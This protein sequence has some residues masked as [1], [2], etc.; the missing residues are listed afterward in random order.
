MMDQTR[1]GQFQSAELSAPEST[2]GGLQKAAPLHGAARALSFYKGAGAR[3]LTGSALLLLTLLWISAGTAPVTA[4]GTVN[5][6]NLVSTLNEDNTT[7][8]NGDPIVYTIIV[9]NG[10]NHSLTDISILDVL[11]ENVLDK[12]ACNNAPTAIPCNLINEIKEI[13]EPLGGTLTVTTTRQISWTVTNLPANSTLTRSFTA[14][15]IGQANGAAFTNI[16]YASYFELG[17]PATTPSNEVKLN[18]LPRIDQGGTTTLS[19]TPTWFSEDVGGTLSSDWADFDGDGDLDLAL[20]STLGTTVYRNDGGQMEQFWTSPRAAYGVRWADVTGDGKPELVAVGAT[21]NSGDA[22]GNQAQLPGIN[23]IYKFDPTTGATTKRFVDLTNFKS[24]K[25]MVRVEVADFNNDGFI[26]IVAST[27]AINPTCA[28]LLYTN[29]GKGNFPSPGTCISVAATAALK[30][31]DF[32]NDGDKDLVLGEFPNK[33]Q[34]LVNENGKFDPQNRVSIEEGALFLPYDFAW[35]DFD[36]DGFLDLAA[37]YPLLREVRI[38]RNLS[39]VSGTD[40]KGSF[41]RPITLRTNVFL[42]PYSIDWGDFSGDGRIDLAVADSPPVIYS[43]TSGFTA[44]SFKP[45]FVLADNVVRGQIWSTRAVD[46]NNDGNLD[47]ALTDRDGPSLVITNFRPPLKTSLT[48]VQGVAPFNN[49]SPASSVAW[50]D[51]NGDSELD[52]LFGAGPAVAGPAA[53]NSK[54]YFNEG[55]QFPPES[56]RTY[57]GFGPHAIAIGDADGNHSLDIAIGSTSEERLHRS[58]EFL[59]P[60]WS[61]TEPGEK[62]LAWGDSDGDSD[63]DLLVATNNGATGKVELF[64]NDHTGNMGDSP[65]WSTDITGTHSIAWGDFDDDGFLDFAVGRDGHNQIWRNNRDNTFSLFWEDTNSYHTHA[66]AWADYD[67]DGDLDL[68]VGNFGVL[69]GP[70]EPNV[71]YENVETDGVRTFVT[72]HALGDEAFHTTSLDWGDYDNDGDL[73]LA[74]G[75]YGEKDQIYINSNSAPGLPQFFWLWSSDEALQTTGIAWGDKD[76]D[77][78]LDLAVSQDGNRLNGIYENNLV[79]PSHLPSSGFGV[80]TLE[81]P[82]MY[83]YVGRPGA[84]S[85]AYNYSSSEILSGPGTGPLPVDFRVYEP[86]RTNSLSVSGLTTQ[87]LSTVEYQFSMD[88]GG[89]WQNATAVTATLSTITDE[90][91]VG[92]QGTYIWNTVRDQA[93]SDNARFRVRI[94]QKDP[95]GPV[96]RVTASATS[97]PFRV[98][99]ITCVWPESPQLLPSSVLETGSAG[100]GFDYLVAPNTDIRFTGKVGSGTGALTYNWDFGNGATALGQVATAMFRDGTYKVRMAVTGQPCPQTRERAVT[101]TLKV[102]TG[103]GDLLLPALFGGNKVVTSTT[104]AISRPIS[105]VVQSAALTSTAPS[106]LPQVEGVAG[107]MQANNGALWLRWSPYSGAAQHLHLYRVDPDAD[108]LTTGRQ[109]VAELPIGATAYQLDAPQCSQE[110]FLVAAGAEGSDQESLPSTS[111]YYTPPCA[112]K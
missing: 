111:S 82:P 47:L 14:R 49:S 22:S 86:S 57:G 24:D 10:T 4:Q 70:G 45:F 7:A 58:G 11:P 8:Y 21:D 69:H 112:T 59:A 29:D 73:D 63:L 62:S 51:A 40:T 80:A 96:Q 33:V 104:A 1:K 88:G 77:G 84:T 100:D 17:V 76:N 61:Q 35:G 71:L 91:G 3:R 97:Y 83:L 99:A 53:L 81:N 52:L 67:K 64:L 75:N 85:P 18:V 27:N 60:F 2:M 15:V 103:N 102:G 34:I 101:V 106:T 74:I 98:R 56:V 92:I 109:L 26:D 55:G 72:R 43:Y 95:G 6:Q 90:L 42:T 89:T 12:I 79:V 54:L 94:V 50:V 110:Y 105:D 20:G 93:I 37:A 38:Y 28:V 87:T 30:P 78:D 44:S 65:V 16:A 23:Y 19:N 39:G 46:Q 68:A 48:P 5:V 25:Q 9:S 66:I 107:D 108:S 31:I 13:P 36:H 41:A 32:D